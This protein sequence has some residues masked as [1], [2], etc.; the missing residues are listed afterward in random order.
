MPS[1]QEL[2]ELPTFDGLAIDL[3][4][5]RAKE[6]IAKDIRV[7]IENQIA[8]LVET[9]PNGQVTAESASGIK[10]VVRRGTN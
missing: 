1:L 8:D 6:S 2:K 7:A 10:I 4:S 3:V 9:D 5:A